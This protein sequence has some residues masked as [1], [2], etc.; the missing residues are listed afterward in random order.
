MARRI[1]VV[2]YDPEWP[3]RFQTEAELLRSCLGPDLLAVH[4][5]GSTSV[6][7]T[8]AKA[9]IDMLLVVPD[10]GVA[11]RYAELL[12]L[13]GYLAKGEFG[14][15]GRRFFIKGT[16][17]IRSHHLHFFARG[18]PRIELYLNFRDYLRVHRDEAIAYGRLKEQL[19]REHS[20]NPD[21][22]MAGKEGMIQELN[23]RAQA[24]KELG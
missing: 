17:E 14:I 2:A 9:I 24:W 13:R 21:A 7:G 15:P 23:R 20:E 16:E 12:E 5:I 18:H 6:P 22:Y 11:D 4:H 19:A 10:I 3:R 8:P 1:T